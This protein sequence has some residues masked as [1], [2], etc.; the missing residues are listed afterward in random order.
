MCTSRMIGSSTAYGAT[1]VLGGG[2]GARTNPIARPVGCY[3]IAKPQGLEQGISGRTGKALKC[4]RSAR[5]N[6]R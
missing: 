3:R 1:G 2:V 4:Q 6:D 5:P